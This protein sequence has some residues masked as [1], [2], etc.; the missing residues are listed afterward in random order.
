[1]SDTDQQF[2]RTALELAERGRGAV[3]PNPMVGCVIVRHGIVIGS[4]YHQQFGGPH[5][6]VEAIRDCQSH[7]NP[8][9]ATAYVT[10]EPC[11]HH[12]KT[13]PCTTALIDAGVQRVV[14]AAQDPFPRVDGGG[15]ERLRQAGIETTVGVLRSQAEAL[16]APY[17]KLVRQGVPWVIGKWAMTLDGRIATTGGESQWITGKESRAEVHRLRGRVDAVIVGVGTALA[18]DPLLTARPPGPRTATRI[19]MCRN[20]LPRLDSKLIQSANEQA[21]VMLVAGPPISHQEFA[22]PFTQL[23]IEVICTSSDTP[24]QMVHDTLRHLGDRRMTNVMLEGGG[25]L[26]SS[27][28]I[29]DQLDECHVYMGG[30]L[31]GGS[32][33]PGPV[34]GSGVAKIAEARHYHLAS[35]CRFDDDVLAVYRKSDE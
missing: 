28:F 14:V 23:G 7:S 9:D 15:V 19:V 6:E 32:D 25:E 18:D 5:A 20:R 24:Q 2:M 11:C 10:L 3:E 26:L 21:K 35:L 29:A 4:G 34:G 31:F 30:K 22:T 17:L 13:P 8:K 33:A 1:M 27:F 16:N 12:G